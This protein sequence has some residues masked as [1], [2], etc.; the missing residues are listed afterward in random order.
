MAVQFF[1]YLSSES[2]PISELS[3]YYLCTW[4]KIKELKGM[5]PMK[6]ETKQRPRERNNL[7]KQTRKCQDKNVPKKRMP[8]ERKYATKTSLYSNSASTLVNSRKTSKN[9]SLL[10]SLPIQPSSPLF[11]TEARK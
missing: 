3:K 2:L 1:Y 6:V 10:S 5:N 8:T 7:F 4:K 9:P 11:T